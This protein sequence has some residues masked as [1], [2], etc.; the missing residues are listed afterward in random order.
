MPLQLN[1]NPNPQAAMLGKQHLRKVMLGGD[2]VWQRRRKQ[3]GIQDL[4]LET[5]EHRKVKLTA[6]NQNGNLFVPMFFPHIKGTIGRVTK[7]GWYC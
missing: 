3:L 4:T 5:L 7:T 6:T 2:V 1:N